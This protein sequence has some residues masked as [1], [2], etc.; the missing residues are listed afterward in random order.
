MS[1][2]YKWIAAILS[3]VMLLALGAQLAL[4]W[5]NYQK[6]LASSEALEAVRRDNS[7]LQT[8]VSSLQEKLG[9]VQD[10]LTELV[11]AGDESYDP[12][13]E[14]D[15]RI[16][17]DYTI[18]STL[19]ISD[20]YQS[21]D[22]SALSDKEK[23]TLDMASAI[24]EKILT[25]DM[26]AYQKEEAVYLWMTSNLAQDEGL[27]PVIPATKA[28]CDN[29]YGVLKYHNAVCV[30]YA[31][32]FRLFMQMLDIPCMVVHNTERFHSWD[33]VQ[34]GDGWY[35]TDIYSDAG[36]P[37]YTHFNLTDAMQSNNQSWNTEF[38]PAAN[39]SEYCYAARVSK[40]IKNLYKIPAA[41]REAMDNRDALFSLRFGNDFGEENAAIVQEMLN[42]IQSRIESSELSRDMYMEWSWMPYEKGWLL[43][44]SMRWYN[45]NEGMPEI[46]DEAYEKINDALEQAFGDLDDY[47]NWDDGMAVG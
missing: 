38:F 31:T 14:D 25:P 17:H 24:L 36:N 9:G 26:D 19:P 29:P 8:E 44:V 16:A 42:Q 23:E 33:L 28:D 4:G 43:A 46:P 15:V 13:Q 39:K 30:G 12:G 21:G 2:A 40:E 45:E 37:S 20:A 47:D 35:H 18:R 5:F 27:L 7:A 11:H 22:A 6:M 3:V 10:Q 41:L 1:K 34:L 32:T